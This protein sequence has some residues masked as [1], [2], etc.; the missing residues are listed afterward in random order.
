MPADAAGAGDVAGDVPC[1]VIEIA[2]ISGTEVV[3]VDE[4]RMEEQVAEDLNVQRRVFQITVGSDLKMESTTQHSKLR[5]T[6]REGKQRRRGGAYGKFD[7]KVNVLRWPNRLT[8]AAS[9]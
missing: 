3:A 2:A 1:A 9:Y 8:S 5:D 7:S 6:G 4:H